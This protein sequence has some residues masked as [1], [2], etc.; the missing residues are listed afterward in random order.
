MEIYGNYQKEVADEEGDYNKILEKMILQKQLQTNKFCKLLARTKGLI[1]EQE[2]TNNQMK[3]IG[4][5]TLSL[6]QDQLGVIKSS[7]RQILKSLFYGRDDLV[8]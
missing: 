1:I 7:N 6:H 3:N 2:L 8:G 5:I 4:M